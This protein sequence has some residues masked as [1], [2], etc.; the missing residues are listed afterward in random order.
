MHSS[1]KSNSSDFSLSLKEQTMPE[2][3][4]KNTF[5]KCPQCRSIYESTI[6]NKIPDPSH[7]EF[8]EI[9]ASF[10]EVCVCMYSKLEHGPQVVTEENVSNLMVALMHLCN[11]ENIDIKK[12]YRSASF[13]YTLD[14]L[15]TE[16]FARVI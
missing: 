1:N 5:I 9:E 7:E 2:I 11:R 3:N 10:A 14:V 16:E 15:S 12:V 13:D 8:R 6:E 4:V